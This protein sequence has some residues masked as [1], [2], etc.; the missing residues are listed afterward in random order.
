MARVEEPAIG[1]DLGTT[2]SCVAVWWNNHVEIIP[3]EMGSRTTPSY[4]SFKDSDRLVGEAAVNLVTMNPLNT[5]FDAKRLI[6]R[7]FSD[8]NL[9]RGNELRPFK[10]VD[11][12]GSGKTDQPM[13]SVKYKDEEK[14]FTPEEITAMILAKMKGVAESFVGRTVNKAVI[15]VPAFF[16]DSQRRATKDAGFIAGFNVVHIINEPTAVAMA[17]Y[18]LDIR[19][20]QR[21]VG[22]KNV[23]VF[24]L[25]GGTFDVSLVVVET[26]K[27]TVKAVNGD[28]HLGGTDFESRMV[29]K[30]ANEFKKKNGKDITKNVRALGRLRVASEKA[31]RV[32]S[33]LPQAD[34][35]IDCLFE[36]YD[37]SSTITRAQFEELNMDLFEKCITL[38]GKC[39]MDARIN[40]MNVDDIV[41]VGGSTRIPKVQQMLQDFFNGKELCKRI[42]PDEAVASGAAMHAFSKS[43]GTSIYKDIVLSDVTPLSL[44]VEFVND[45]MKVLIPRNTSIPTKIHKS[46]SL[47]EDNYNFF[48]FGVYE[49]E[50]AN[51]KYNNFLGACEFFGVLFP[52]DTTKI[53]VDFNVDENGILYVTSKIVENGGQWNQTNIMRHDGRL[54]KA[55]MVRMINEAE[56]YK[57]QDEKRRK[58]LQAKSALESYVDIISDRLSDAADDNNNNNDDDVKLEMNKKKAARDSALSMLE[59]NSDLLETSLLENKLKELKS[60]FEDVQIQLH[61]DINL[62]HSYDMCDQ[63]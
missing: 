46:Y 31:K 60:I 47:Y 22:P 37:F 48:K 54:K 44:G 58:L 3:N 19:I 25:G 15:S 34:V 18:D 30:F 16:S 11:G 12:I 62:L 23:L 13:I 39:L 56:N 40:K 27:I 51:I 4:V 43:I 26:G 63:V 1:I 32:L 8:D 59:Q 35:Q 5:I 2:N 45:R 9:Q 21:N 33:L 49:G 57:T 52:G 42:H 61:G 29:R 36:D 24:D 41:L 7:R 14:L 20:N 28:T 17:Y 50:N 10:V 53:H 6:G 55:E 38:V